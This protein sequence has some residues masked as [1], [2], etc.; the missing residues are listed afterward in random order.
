MN[1]KK[2]SSLTTGHI[3]RIRRQWQLYVY[4]YIQLVHVYGKCAYEILI[5]IS[6]LI[7]SCMVSLRDF[8]KIT[9]HD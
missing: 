5:K 6:A 8:N 3:L 9:G 2:K 1:S 7:R 4:M